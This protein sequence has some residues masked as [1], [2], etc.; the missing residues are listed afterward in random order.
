MDH[1]KLKPF[2]AIPGPKG[3]VI[4]GTL[5]DYLKKDGF[6]F[7]KMF[8]VISLREAVPWGPSGF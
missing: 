2:D 1:Q 4:I 6:R 5:W 7:N 8:K 3:H